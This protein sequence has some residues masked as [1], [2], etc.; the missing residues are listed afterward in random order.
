[1]VT[2]PPTTATASEILQ[3]LAVLAVLIIL[4]FVAILPASWTG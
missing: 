4:A 2:R 1:M 3:A